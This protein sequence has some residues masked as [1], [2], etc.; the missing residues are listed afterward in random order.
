[1]QLRGWAGPMQAPGVAPKPTEGQNGKRGA[2]GKTSGS[3]NP[4]SVVEDPHA[5]L[6]NLGL[7]EWR[8]SWL[9]VVGGRCW[10]R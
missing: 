9:A 1:M 3:G 7:G 8:R 2:P 4:D 6:H 5:M 10:G